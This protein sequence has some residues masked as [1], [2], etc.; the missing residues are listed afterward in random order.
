MIYVIA[1]LVG[2]L[3][4]WVTLLIV[5]P[6][7]QKLADFGLPAWPQLLWQVA[8]VAAIV[9]AVSMGLQSV[10]GVLEWL[11]TSVVF[12]VLMVKWFNVD[13]FGA[14]IIVVVN[15]VVRFVVGLMLVG[16]IHF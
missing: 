1:F 14:V 11:V 12:W 5:L 10:G 4:T 16:L 3:I 15:L 13:F 6:L 8:L 7:A 9:N 2:T